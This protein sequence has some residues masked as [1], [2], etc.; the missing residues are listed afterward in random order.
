MLHAAK[1]AFSYIRSSKALE[2]RVLQQAHFV[3]SS[4]YIGNLLLPRALHQH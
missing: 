3:R 2:L 4:H 1:I